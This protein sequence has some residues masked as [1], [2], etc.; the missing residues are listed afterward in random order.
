MVSVLIT[1]PPVLCVL[2]KLTLVFITVSVYLIQIPLSQT[3]FHTSGGQGALSGAT[4]SAGTTKHIDN[5]QF[6]VVTQISQTVFSPFRSVPRA[7]N[8]SGT[9]RSGISVTSNP[10]TYCKSQNQNRYDELD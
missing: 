8:G 10:P 1:H 3:S 2:L 6:M 7:A 5:N 9:L 4:Q